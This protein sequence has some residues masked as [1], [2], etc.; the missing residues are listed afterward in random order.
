M[1]DEARQDVRPSASP[2]CGRPSAVSSRVRQDAG[3]E[4]QDADVEDLLDD[5][6]VVDADEVLDDELLDDEVEVVDEPDFP[7]ERES[8]R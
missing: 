3:V 5:V 6:D 7:P 2:G 4:A 8:V 1:D